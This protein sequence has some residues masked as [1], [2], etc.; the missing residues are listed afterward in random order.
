[1]ANKNFQKKKIQDTEN[2]NFGKYEEG[3]GGGGSPNGKSKPSDHG[4]GVNSDYREE[5]NDTMQPRTND[6]KFTYKSVNGK[7]IDPKYGPS[8]G[9]TVNPLLTG[10]E[11]GVK[12]DDVEKDFYNKSGKYWNKYKDKWYH[13]GGEFVTNKDF[14]VRVAAEAIWNVAK[15]IYNEVTGEFG[16]DINFSHQLNNGG[17]KDASGWGGAEEAKTFAETKKGRRGMEEKAAIQKAK[18]AKDEQAVIDQSTGGIK[19]KPG[20]TIQPPQPAP[21]P[22]PGNVGRSGTTPF[23]PT[24]PGVPTSVNAATVTDIANADYTPKYS[25][26]DIAQARQVL[27]DSGLSD[28]D[29]ADFDSLSPKE[30]DAYI[31][32]YFMPEEDDGGEDNGDANGD[33]NPTPASEEA[34]PEEEESEAEKK[35][36]AMGFSD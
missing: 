28:T 10:G 34:K 7:S 15:R 25:D 29:L 3:I 20:V 22:Q 17:T 32:Q 9:K 24:Q 18:K 19:L 13:K 35:I 5:N 23:V 21:Q 4:H 36:K 8:R 12:I 1:M 26:D 11:N 31:D 27:A 6:G 2:S 14:K 33:A 30:K 16:G